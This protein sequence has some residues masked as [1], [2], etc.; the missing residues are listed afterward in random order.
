MEQKIAINRKFVTSIMLD[1]DVVSICFIDT[2][3]VNK[4]I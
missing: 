2:D 1:D 3:Y 4:K